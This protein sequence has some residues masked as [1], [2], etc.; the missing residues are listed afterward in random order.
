MRE[1]DVC[2]AM[3]VISELLSNAIRHAR[4][5]PG[6][7]IEVSWTLDGGTLEVAVS[8]GGA[9][10]TPQPERPPASSLGGRGLD[11]V[12]H[13]SRSW[14]VRGDDLGTTVWAVLPARQRRVRQP[15]SRRALSAADRG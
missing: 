5:L 2:D 4:P 8:D 10:T 13:L 9:P 12:D 14:G 3:L 6:G 11:I 1:V 15:R 7:Q